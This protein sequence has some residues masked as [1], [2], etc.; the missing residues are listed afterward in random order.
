M[1][2]NV[3]DRDG[4]IQV[5]LRANGCGGYELG[6]DRMRVRRRRTDEDERD[7]V[8]SGTTALY[9]NAPAGV[10]EC[11]SGVLMSGKPMVVLGMIVIGV[12][13][14]V[15]RGDLC[16]PG[17]ERQCEQGRGQATHTASV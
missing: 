7:R 11:G 1:D 6:V 8:I 15:Q 14:D 12:V 2:A 16:R 10:M 13:V 17:D 4:L 9:T 3:R 5:G